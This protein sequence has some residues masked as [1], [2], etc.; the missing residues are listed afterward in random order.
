MLDCMSKS[1][2]SRSREV[3]ILL[4]S[5]LVQL[6][7]EHC[8][9]TFVPQH[10]SAKYKSEQ[11]QQQV[12]AMVKGLEQLMYKKMLKELCLFSLEKRRLWGNKGTVFH[13]WKGVY[14]EDG[15]RLFSELHSEGQ[16]QMQAAINKTPMTYEEKNPQWR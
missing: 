7:L 11:A 14:R 9:F 12:T 16:Q 2:V 4:H 8:G 5:T 3:V 13:F 10:N 6:H 1:I 15:A